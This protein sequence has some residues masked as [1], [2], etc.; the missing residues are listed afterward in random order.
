MVLHL[1]GTVR[2]TTYQNCDIINMTLDSLIK[3]RI[4]YLLEIAVSSTICSTF[5]TLLL[6]ADPHEIIL[7]YFKDVITNQYALYFDK[8]IFLHSDLKQYYEIIF[9]SSILLYFKYFYNKRNAQWK[10]IT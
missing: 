1:R 4:L 5:Y 9:L 7:F 6:K 2:Y 3:V 10:Q 8:I